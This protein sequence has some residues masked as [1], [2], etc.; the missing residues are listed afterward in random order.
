MIWDIRDWLR[1]RFVRWFVCW[2]KGHDISAG[3]SEYAGGYSY[4]ITSDF[5]ER[6]WNSADDLRYGLWDDQPLYMLK[7][8]AD[9]AWYR[10][11]RRFKRAQQ[12]GDHE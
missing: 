9:I 10:I 12:D 3:E 7:N 2:R 1:M 11:K 5:C 8:E 6:C 4:Q